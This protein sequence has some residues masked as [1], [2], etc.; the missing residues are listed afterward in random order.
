[1]V[2]TAWGA[3]ALDV[4]ATND[5]ADPTVWPNRASSANSDRWLVEH[6]DQ[7]RSMAPRILVLNFANGCTA[8]RAEVT[9]RELAAAL[10]ESSRYHGYEKPEAPAFLRPRILKVVDLTDPAPFPTTPDGNSTRFPRV[11]NWHEG[12]FNFVYRELYSDRFAQFYG[13]ASPDQP[14][15]PLPL[16]ELVARGIVHEVWFLAHHGKAGAPYECTELKPVYDEQF[17]RVGDEH[18]HAGNGGD[19]D[20]PWHGRSLRITFINWQRGIGC[21]LEN[22]GHALEGTASSRVIPYFTRYFGEYAGFDLDKRYGAPFGS[23]YAV[24]YGQSALVYSDPDMLTVT[25]GE[26]RVVLSPYIPIGGNVH[27]PPNGRRHYDLDNPQPVRSTIEHYRRFDGPDGRDLAAPWSID[28]FARYRRTMPDCMGPWLTYWRQNMPGLD[29]PCRD[30][31]G[32]PMK[33]WW[34]FLYY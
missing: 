33:N 12:M 24:N 16:A 21:A 32:R 26:R 25:H 20:E 34:P 9:A 30:D 13:I 22:F 4:V 31:A 19:P 2:L 11:P 17:R 15:R 18:R 29:N 27:F 5:P 28:S 23:F 1:M 3:R 10:S 8:A 7:L 6:H 14:G